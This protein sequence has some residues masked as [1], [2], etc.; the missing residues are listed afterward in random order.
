MTSTY[1][2]C[3]RRYYGL[4]YCKPFTP[5]NYMAN[6]VIRTS[7]R[8]SVPPTSL[9]ELRQHV[10][11]PL[12]GHTLFS[13][14]E[15]LRANHFAHECEDVARLIRWGES[16]QAE[17]FRREVAAQAEVAYLRRQCALRNTLR[18]LHPASFRCHCP[19]RPAP[20]RLASYPPL[21]Q[22]DR[23]AGTFDRLAAARF[24]P[25]DSLTFAGLLSILRQ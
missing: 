5:Q 15:Q 24:Q 16:V 3:L 6:H 17:I 12:I 20:A 25:L 19:R 1:S 18:Q 2:T 14:A 13:D 21:D 22:A 7:T 4:G 8:L 11:T 9:G 10:L 23:R